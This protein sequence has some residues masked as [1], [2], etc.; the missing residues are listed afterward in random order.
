[1]EAKAIAEFYEIL[2]N[3]ANKNTMTKNPHN[4]ECCHILKLNYLFKKIKKNLQIL[5]VNRIR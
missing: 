4:P 5:F 3:A 2:L 1:M